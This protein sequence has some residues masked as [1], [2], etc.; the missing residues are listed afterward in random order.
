MG[1]PYAARQFVAWVLLSAALS[2]LLPA[3]SAA[4][5]RVTSV[6]RI[7]TRVKVGDEV[8]VTDGQGRNVRGRIVSLD[9]TAL[10]LNAGGKRVQLAEDDIRQVK[11][12]YRDS[13][14]DGAVYG[15][16]VGVGGFLG[17]AY[18]GDPEMAT[19]PE[20][21][22]G[23]IVLGAGGGAIAGFII[24]RCHRGQRTVYRR[25]PSGGAG[26]ALSVVPVIAPRTKAVALSYSF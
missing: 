2:V 7:S 9:A 26:P 6:D 14:W 17:V 16:A 21:L 22:P 3:L 12:Y 11:Q 19:D 1:T 24:D 23:L 5:T 18:A 10:V 4:Q 20:A 13:G 8:R 25:P 15:A